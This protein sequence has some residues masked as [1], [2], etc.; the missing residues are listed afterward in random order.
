[1][2]LVTLQGC[3]QHDNATEHNGSPGTVAGQRGELRQRSRDEKSTPGDKR[4][5]PKGKEN[6]SHGAEVQLRLAIT[7]AGRMI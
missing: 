5:G 6:V 4:Q 2:P 1:M 3:K 7:R